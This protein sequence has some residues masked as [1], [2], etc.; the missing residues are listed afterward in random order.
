MQHNNPGAP[1]EGSEQL[2]ARSEARRTPLT[3]ARSNQQLS[4]ELRPGA[5]GEDAE[6]GINLFD[7]WRILVK[8]RWLVLSTTAMVLVI[9]LVNTLLTTPIYRAVATIQIEPV[10]ANSVQVGGVAAN[11]DY[12]FASDFKQTQIDLI[13]SRTLAKRIVTQMGLVESG[14]MDRLWPGSVW[15]KLKAVV[16]PDPANDDSPAPVAKSTMDKKTADE[17]ANAIAGLFRNG[18]SVDPV[19]NSELV[20]VSYDSPNPSFSQ[21]AANAVAEAFIAQNLD[22][23][24]DTNSYAKNYLEDSLQSLKLKLEDSERK[25]VEFTSKE[26]IVSS[27][28]VTGANLLEQDLGTMN[29]ALAQAR[30]DRIKAE[31]RWKQSPSLSPEEL[32]NTTLQPLIRNL[33]DS[34]S[35]LLVQYQD[36]LKLYKPDYPQMQQ[37]KGQIDE[38]EKQIKTEQGNLRNSV[39]AE[40]EAALQQEQALQAQVEQLKTAVLDLQR[41]S[42]QYYT[43]KREVDTNRQLYDALLQRYKDIG[44]ASGVDSNNISIVDRAERGSKILPNMSKNLTQGLLAGLMLGI[45]LAFAFEYLDDTLKRPEDIE[46]LLGL[47]VLGAIP[48]LKPPMTPETAMADARSAFSEAYRSLRTALQFSTDRGVPRTLLITS[49]TANEGK[50]TTAL[51]LGQY[52]AQLGKRVLIVD[53]DLRNPS[54]HRTLGVDNNQGLSNYLSGAGKPDL[55]RPTTIP[56]LSYLPTGPLPPNPAELLMGSK[57]MSVLTVAAEKFDLLILDGPPILGL[58]DAPILSNLAQ[59]TLLVVHAEQTRIAVVKSAIKRL[60]A[61]RAHIVG[62]L[63]TH[64]QPEHSGQGYAYGGY[65]HYTYG[66]GRPLLTR[67]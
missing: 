22:R 43:L 61:A 28:S 66:T 49:A 6:E 45:L 31:A 39:R 33:Q 65:D 9:A 14:E 63:L 54:L 5:E 7:Y 2:P 52:F 59:G 47:P 19:W 15:Q 57:M 58:A 1:D 42:I 27:G 34:R 4:L 46:K 8:R 32:Q 18:L 48:M 3:I 37:L 29:T 23:R 35:K 67:K 53:C 56:G 11:F 30:L 55:I 50:S 40:Y 10:S 38:I 60:H 12:N 26:Q 16:A 13:K 24:V 64:F 36:Q 62:G 51:A 25:L 20:S 17:K 21:R 41:R 44:I